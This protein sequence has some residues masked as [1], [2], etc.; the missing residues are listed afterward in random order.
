MDD[1]DIK[2]ILNDPK[3][4]LELFSLFHQLLH[5]YESQRSR[6]PG[7]TESVGLSDQLD[8]KVIK[9]REVKQ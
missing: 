3:K 4:L 7:T 1:K 6:K 9:N 2:E 8:I 5:L